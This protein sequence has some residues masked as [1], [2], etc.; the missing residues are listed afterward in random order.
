MKKLIAIDLRKKS[1]KELLEDLNKISMQLLK[2]KILQSEGEIN[3][4]HIFSVMKK[5]IARLLTV[6]GEE[7]ARKK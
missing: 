4:H 3:K 7:N 1:R 2:S 6:L 5:N